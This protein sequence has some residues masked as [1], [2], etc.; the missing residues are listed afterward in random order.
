[1]KHLF[2]CLCVLLLISCGVLV[3]ENPRSSS[4]IIATSSQNLS[5]SS[6]IPYPVD[7]KTVIRD[8]FEDDRDGKVYKSVKIGD[9]TWMAQNL[10]YRE[11]Y[12]SYCYEKSDDTCAKYG[13]IYVDAAAL[14]LYRTDSI[15]W[16]I[17]DQRIDSLYAY[18]WKH[19]QGVCPKD[20]HIPDSVEV[21][22]LISAVGGAD[23]S[24]RL[25]SASGWPDSLKGTDEFGFNFKNGPWIYFDPMARVLDP[26]VF[27]YSQSPGISR[28]WIVPNQR[29]AS[30]NSTN[31]KGLGQLGT[32]YLYVRCVKDF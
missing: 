28:I 2:P 7:P 1:M 15:Y 5:S 31:F 21:L 32:Q 8:S 26:S 14:A 6:E 3:D 20:W 13:R 4:S 9:L 10:D 29:G 25:R 11:S 12:N 24:Y 23:S 16:Y 22:N 19:W 30:P 27:D 18:R 17:D